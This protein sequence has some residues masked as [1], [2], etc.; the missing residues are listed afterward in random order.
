LPTNQLNQKIPSNT[1][2][3]EQAAKPIHDNVNLKPN[4]DN[5]N[6]STQPRAT[7]KSESPPKT[8]NSPSTVTK[9]NAQSDFSS[10]V[11]SQT[12][13]TANKKP[14][15]NSPPPKSSQDKCE[16]VLHEL[17]KLEKEVEQFSGRKNEKSFLKIDEYL[18][19]CLLKLDE[20]ERTDEKLNQIRKRLINY[21][22]LLS[23]KLEARA[24]MNE[25]NEKKDENNNQNQQQ[26]QKNISELKETVELKNDD[27]NNE[28]KST[29][30]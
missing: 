26:E 9:P 8:N 28:V 11:N 2:S 25:N 12:S 22:Q 6:E 30:L 14:N 17:N 7:L 15:E 10:P 16:E 18:T 20:I 1:L 19:R 13:E 23:D 5:L 21:T 3:N 24:L 4:S 27:N 29:D